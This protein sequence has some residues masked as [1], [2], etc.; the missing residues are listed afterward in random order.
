[1]ELRCR[2]NITCRKFFQCWIHWFEN[3]GSSVTFRNL[4][5]KSRLTTLSCCIH[6]LQ[7]QNM[8]YN[9]N[10]LSKY[11]TRILIQSNVTCSLK[12]VGTWGHWR[13]WV[14]CWRYVFSSGFWCKMCDDTGVFNWTFFTDFI[15]GFVHWWLPGSSSVVASCL[16]CSLF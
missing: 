12:K 2:I 14:S 13:R 3:L 1:M 9:R 8:E 10:S 6:N 11:L 16:L 4:R 15:E 7:P 5:S